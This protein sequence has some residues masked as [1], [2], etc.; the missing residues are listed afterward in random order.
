[1]KSRTVQTL[2]FSI[3]D[4]PP[5]LLRNNIFA[6][7]FIREV[8][9]VSGTDHLFG[10]FIYLVRYCIRQLE[11]RSA[12]IIGKTLLYLGSFAYLYLGHHTCIWRRHSYNG[13]GKMKVFNAI[14]PCSCWSITMGTNFDQTVKRICP[15]SSRILFSVQFLALSGPQ[16][17]RLFLRLKTGIAISSQYVCLR[18]QREKKWL[19]V[20][21]ETLY[22]VPVVIVTHAYSRTCRS[23]LQWNYIPCL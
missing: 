10:K 20:Y 19:V 4:S 17:W 9:R 15:I 5:F 12:H 18:A 6:S 22:L 16:F 1:M 2:I 13:S 3:R 21:N 14:L 8:A 7:G 11:M 23:I